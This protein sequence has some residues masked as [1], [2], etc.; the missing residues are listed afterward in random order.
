MSK[1]NEEIRTDNHNEDDGSFRI[2][3][4]ELSQSQSSL[5]DAESDEAEAISLQRWLDLNA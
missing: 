1:G 5:P 2:L 3:H 4:S